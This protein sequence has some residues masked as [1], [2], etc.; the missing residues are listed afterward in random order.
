M[1]TSIVHVARWWLNDP[2]SA[3]EFLE[4]ASELSGI[5][6]VLEVSVGTS[7]EVGWIGPDQSWDVGFVVTFDSYDSVPGYLAHPL[8]RAVVH[9]ASRIASRIDVFYLDVDGGGIPG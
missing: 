2:T 4:V 7:T 3:R 6:G 5:P 1:S 9:L 8:H